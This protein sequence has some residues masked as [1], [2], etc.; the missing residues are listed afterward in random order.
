[1][2]DLLLRA[3]ALDET[4]ESSDA[5]R[6][7]RICAVGQYAFGKR[8]DEEEE[9]EEKAREM[10]AGLKRFQECI[11]LQVVATPIEYMHTV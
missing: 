7:S 3:V 10:R 6:V 11:N 9:E 5:W 2:D 8:D 1:M 4:S